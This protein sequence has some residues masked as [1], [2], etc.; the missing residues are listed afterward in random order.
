MSIYNTTVNKPISTLMVF[1]AILVLGIASYIQLPVDQYPKMDPP[2]IT[3]MATYPG[4]NASDIEENVTK[5]LENQ[6]NSVDNLKE[7]TSTSYDNLAVVALEFEWEVNLDEASNDVRD[8]VDKAMQALPDGIDRPTIMRFNTSM[9]PILIY[10]VTADASYPGIDKILD[11]K[12]VTRLNRVD[13]VASVI[14]AG[15]PERVVYVDLDPNQLDAYNLTLEQIG[16][17]ILAE[18]RDIS[19]GSV[20]MGEMDYT[21][22]IEGEFEE[23][24][25]IKNLVLGTQNNKTIYL[26]DVARVRDTIKDITLEQIINRGNGGVL[27]VTKQTDANAV[28]VAKEAKEQLEVA[29]KELPSDIHFQIISDNS[30]FIVKSINNLQQTLMYALIFVVLVV[31][32]FL[33]RWRATFIIAL[34]IP[35]SLIVAFIYLFATGESLNV[36][37]LSSLSIAIGMV[38]D[39]AIVVLENITKHVDRGSRPREAAKYGTNEVWLSVIV[40]TLVTVAVFFPLTLVTGMTGILFKQLGWIVCITVCTS[41]VTAISLT[42]MLCSQLMKVQEKPKDGKFSFYNFVSTL[43]DRL[44]SAYEK[45]IRWVLCHKTVVICSMFF[46]FFGSCGLMRFIK[47]DFMPQNDQNYMNV[48]AKMQSGQ[49]VEVTKEVALQIDSVMRAEIPE[50][51][52]INLSYGSEEEAS[53]ASMM[54]STGNNILNMRVRVV[55]IKERDRSVFEIA[56]QVRGILK[57]FPD[58]LQYTVSTSNG[59]SMGGN[60]VD[61]EIMGHDF[62]VTTRLAHE[63]AQKARQIPG[64][65]DIKISRDEDKSELQVVLD[66]DKLAR[67]GLTTSEVGSY[68]RNRI[69]GFRNSKFKENGEEYDIIVRLDEKYRSSLTEVENILI[70]DNRGQKVRLKELGEIK[71]YFSPPN[72][73]RKS[74]QRLLKVSITP[75]A[76]IALGDI[77]QATQQMLDGLED[78][79]QEVSLYIGGR[80]E[81]QQESFSSLIMLLLLSLMLVYIVMAAQFESFKMP[82]IIMLSI[83]FAFTGVI[84]ALLLSNT[85]LSIVAALGAIMLVGIVTKNGIVLIDFINLMRERGIRLYDAIAQAC[86]SR[87]RPVLMTSLTTILGMVPMA[88]SVGEGAETWRPMGIAVIGGMIFSTIITM[89]IVPAVYASMDKSG[90]RNKNKAL[91]KQFKFMSDFDPERDLPRKN[92]EE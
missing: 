74:K 58:V 29:L 7:L 42:P 44:D 54:N 81:D 63:I 79:P 90:S 27:M 33:G 45:L 9:M 67:H 71:E 70:T 16:N 26:H 28:A 25:Q 75:A 72:I 85:T 87:L 77:A 64:A 13:G 30:D 1:I 61:V 35:I 32:L 22:R 23:S 51:R 11:D 40:T 69:Y 34:T 41:T 14:V 88:F 89:I 62:N 12:L 60:S 78:V 10:A 18:N 6:L 2:Y 24:D 82:F 49:R 3:V 56:D 59:G 17:K 39:D 91:E 53:F 68:L 57:R 46:L 84:L 66:P 36:I 47:T 20:K 65:E 50:I 31:F 38:V 76:G 73:E 5:I 19:A 92:R 37:S 52:I 83:P 48:Y 80:Y 8:A 15:A 86:R 4:A 55:D 21:L 43:L